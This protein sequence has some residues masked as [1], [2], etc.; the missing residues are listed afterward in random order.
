MKYFN[1]IS[2]TALILFTLMA[3]SKDEFENKDVNSNLNVETTGLVFS[4]QVASG[5]GF[6][7]IEYGRG[8]RTSSTTIL[9]FNDLQ[10]VEDLATE[11]ENQ[12]DIWNDNFV[13]QWN[14][15]TDD[16]LDAKKVQLGFDDDQPLTDFENANSMTSSLRRKFLAEEAIWL[17]NAILDDTNDPNAK[18]EYGFDNA[19]MA[20]MNNQGEIKVQNNIY[21]II[22]DGYLNISDGDLQKLLRYNEGDMTVLNEPGVSIDPY[23]NIDDS[24]SVES[25]KSGCKRGSSEGYSYY[26]TNRR[27]FLKI[28]L[29]SYPWKAVA[30][31]QI[32]SYK[33][34]GNSWKRHTRTM[35]AGSFGTIY[36]NACSNNFNYSSEYKTKRR[37]EL[38]HRRE[39]WEAFPD[40]KTQSGQLAG[41]FIIGGQYKTVTLQ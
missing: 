20:L 35:S 14:S 2:L 12:V 3:C 33:K 11:L 8:G 10:A 18:L 32:I 27:A 29:R 6:T 5:N 34:T 26:E 1:Q 39:W 31:S 15:L 37:K 24:N 38:Y 40:K 17:N 19:V 4:K 7:V 28:S 22:V 23:I 9:N 13:S 36:N 30:K 25:S 41:K 16:Q 21:K